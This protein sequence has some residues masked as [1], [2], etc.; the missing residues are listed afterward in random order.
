MY[1]KAWCTCKVVVLLIGAVTHTIVKGLFRG[2]FAA[3]NFTRVNFTKVTCGYTLIYL[4]RLISVFTQLFSRETLGGLSE[5]AGFSVS[6]ELLISGIKR[7][8]WPRWSRLNFWNFSIKWTS[9]WIQIR[10][11]SEKKKNTNV[12]SNYLVCK[13]TIVSLKTILK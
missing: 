5:R 13:Q 10:I 1:K 6:K 12:C 8:T 2:K 3:V 4:P 9:E 7:K 11:C